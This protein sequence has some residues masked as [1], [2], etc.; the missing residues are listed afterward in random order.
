MS[1]IN[2]RFA[3][4]RAFKNMNRKQFA[5]DLGINQSVVGDIELGKREP[6]REVLSR[7]AE[8]YN[9]NINWLLTDQGKMFQ[10]DFSTMPIEKDGANEPEVSTSEGVPYYDI[11]VA[12]HIS[13]MLIDPK[14][15]PDF[16][17]NF[18]PF[19]DCTAYLPTYGD[20]MFPAIQAGDII[21]VKQINNWDVIQWGEPYVIV[22][23]SSANN[24]RTVKLIYPHDDKDKIILRASNPNFKGDTVVSKN[25]ILSMFIVKGIITRKQL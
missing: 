23:N 6:S 4:I 7:L 16:Y 17:V 24:M 22:T 12:A 20:S 14:T 3:D 25:D 1:T 21:A 5:D 13:E 10:E 15:E 19:N 9:I 8:R 18:K 2:R 11:D